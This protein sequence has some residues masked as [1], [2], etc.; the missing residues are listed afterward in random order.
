MQEGFPSSMRHERMVTIS[1]QSAEYL[2]R[3][4]KANLKGLGITPNMW[5]YVQEDLLEGIQVAKGNEKHP[6]LPHTPS[7][8]GK[9]IARKII[10]I[11]PPF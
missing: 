8:K 5:K 6:A 10:D 3:L 9:P 7:R 4:H 11:E 2:Y 1:L